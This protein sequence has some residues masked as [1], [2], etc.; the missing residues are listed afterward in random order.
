MKR[1]L[2]VLALCAG[3]LAGVERRFCLVTAYCPCARCTDGDGITA[4]GK[5]VVGVAMPDQWGVATCWEAIPPGSRIVVPGY[6]P[7]RF[8]PEGF[9]WPVD[10]TGSQMRTAWFRPCEHRINPQRSR[11]LHIDVRFIHHANAAKWGA[12]WLWVTI[13][14]PDEEPKPI[15]D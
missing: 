4:T 10:D 11:F 6:K 15:S 8:W 14:Y 1:T 2:L 13:Y 12:R 5:R 3:T 7:S 9:A